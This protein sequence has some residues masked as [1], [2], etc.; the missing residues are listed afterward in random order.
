MAIDR[1]LVDALKNACAQAWASLRRAHP[2]EFIYAFGI[3]GTTE[4][5]YF[6]PFACGEEGLARAAGSYVVKGRYDTLDEAKARLRWS[7]A[8]SPY[9]Q[10]MSSWARAIDAALAGRPDPMEMDEAKA[11][12]EIRLRFNSA[13]A[14]LRELDAQGVFNDDNQRHR[15]ILLIEAGDR[16]EDFVLGHAKKLNPPDIFANFRQQLA[17]PAWGKYTELG[18]KKVYHTRGLALSAGN[19]AG[20][21]RLYAIADTM[22]FA[23][24]AA[25]QRQLWHA[26]IRTGRQTH[27]ACVVATPACGSFLAAGTYGN[28]AHLAIWSDPSDPKSVAVHTLAFTPTA[29]AAEPAGRFMAIGGNDQHVHLVLP[30][31]EQTAALPCDGSIPNGVDISP[32][33]L[34]VA[35]GVGA[36]GAWLWR[37]E[38]GEWKHLRQTVIPAHNVRF[39]P[40][41]KTFLTAVRHGLTAFLDPQHRDALILCDTATGHRLHE[42]RADGFYLYAPAFDPS[43]QRIACCAKEPW[44]EDRLGDPVA[45]ECFIFDTAS[46]R[47]LD[48][49]RL[50]QHIDCFNQIEFLKKDTMAVAAWG[51]TLRPVVLWH[52]SASAKNAKPEPRGGS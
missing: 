20:G 18:T 45:D 7:V 40:D 28:G 44:K 43:G 8:D 13:I 30:D 23:F 34:T 50:P 6:L 24:D 2:A 11:A 36:L 22:V 14:A 4:A 38:G 48:R 1:L 16:T 15:R 46:G 39:A 52:T 49:L 51:H 9:H 5:E 32:D 27:P 31:G 41:G 17:R 42:Y 21:A 35:A 26:T 3:F 10:S 37:N 33:G 47:L 29:I 12:R 25:Q 19:A